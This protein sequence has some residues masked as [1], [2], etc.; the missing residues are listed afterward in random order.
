MKNTILLFLGI[1]LLSCEG[2]Y[3]NPKYKS[4]CGIGNPK[5][6]LSWIENENYMNSP[7]LKG[8]YAYRYYGFIE[9]EDAPFLSD[10]GFFETRN[11]RE[12]VIVRISDQKRNDLKID[13]WLH[14]YT[15]DGQFINEGWVE[16][17]ISYPG[18]L[19]KK[20]NFDVV[21]L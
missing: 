11:P 18:K 8:S 7:S 12:I 19:K 13:D 15:C 10:M 17:W 4:E 6:K 5:K 2:I 16:E 9:K 3:L 21:Q 14:L 20:Y 1:S